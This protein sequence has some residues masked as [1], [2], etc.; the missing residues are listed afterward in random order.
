MFGIMC[1]KLFYYV[2]KD[3][4]EIWLIFH[5]DTISKSQLRHITAPG[6]KKFILNELEHVMIVMQVKTVIELCVS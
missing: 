1:R 3:T 4:L 6:K 5:F 2:A